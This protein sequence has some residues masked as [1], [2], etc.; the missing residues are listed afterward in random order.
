MPKTA[1]YR[2]ME[3]DDN[4]PCESRVNTHPDL[5]KAGFLDVTDRTLPN[6]YGT[7][8]GTLHGNMWSVLAWLGIDD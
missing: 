6:A 7:A 8:F 1:L 2:A 5:G 3:G 4:R